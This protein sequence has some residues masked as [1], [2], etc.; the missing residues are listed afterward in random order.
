LKLELEICLESG[1]SWK[2][3]YRGMISRGENIGIYQRD[4]C[5]E[6]RIRD[7]SGK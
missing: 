1:K 7:V 3:I 5:V 2:E 6:M 4:R